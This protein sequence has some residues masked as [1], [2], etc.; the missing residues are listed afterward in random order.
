MGSTCL[1]PDRAAFHRLT[2]ALMTSAPFGST[3][4]GGDATFLTWRCLSSPVPAQPGYII[5]FDAGGRTFGADHRMLMGCGFRRRS[6]L[7]PQQ[8]PKRSR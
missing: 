4:G 3:T 5:S 7:R 2:R 1:A 6:T 8:G